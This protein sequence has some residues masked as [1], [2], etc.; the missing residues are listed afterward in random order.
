MIT[1]R[2]MAFCLIS[3]A[4]YKSGTTQ[5]VALDISK[6]FNRVWHSSFLYKCRLMEF[7]VIYLTLFCLFRWGTLLYKSLFPFV[8]S[9]VCPSLAHHI[10]GTVHHRIIFFGT[11]WKMMLSPGVFFSY[12]LD[13]I[14]W[15][16]RGVKGQNIPKW[17]IITFVT[18]HISGAGYHMI[19][20]FGT[21][22]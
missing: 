19:I 4:F 13:L 7:L 8:Q 21:D 18:C 16:A 10:S 6:A 12:F 3:R 11:L 17:K 9:S 5:T 15:A 20:I 14:F 1:S 22:V 2:N